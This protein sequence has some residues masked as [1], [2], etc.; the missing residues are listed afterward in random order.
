MNKRSLLPVLSTALLAPAFL[1]GQVY[2]EEA[3]TP[4]ESSAVVATPATSEA[5]APVSN[6][7]ASAT[8]TNEVETPATVAS[9]EAP[10]A[11]AESTKSEE[12]DTV[13]LHT[14]DVHGRIVEEKGVIGDAKLA[15]VIE[16][17]RAKSNQ[18]TLVVDAGDAFQGLPISNSTKGEARAEIL[19]QMQYDAMA[20]GNHEF[21]F[22]L[23]E[24]KKYKE[25]LKFP[26]LSSNTYVNGARLF[27]AS[28]IVDKD[29]TVEGDEFVVIGVTTP[30]TATKTHPKNI[31]GVTFTDPISEVNKVIEE[32][33]AKARAEGKDYK[34][35][36]VLAHL[37]VD[38]TTPVEWRGSTLAEALS[39]NPRLKGKRVTVIDGHSHTVASTTYGNNV[40]Y[41]QTGSYLHNVGKV[42]Y[43]SRQLLGNPTLIAAADAKKLT[44]NPKVEKLVK[45]IKQ[46]YDAE[47]AVE[48]VSNSPVELNGDRENVRVRETNLGNVVADSLYQYGQTGFSHPTDI[49]VTNG[50]GL[51]ET[52]AKGK[53][54]T[55]GN[56]IAVLPFG[57]T[58]SQ[59]Q[60]TGQ[61]VL[62]MF[63]KSLGS[64]LQVD[65]D[66]KKVLDENGQPLLEPSGGFLQVSG[67]KVYYDTN[68]PSGKRVLA[69][70]AKNRTTG[71]YDLLDLAKTYYLATNDFLAAGGDGYTM[72][73]GAREEG[74]SMDAAFEEYLKTA[75]LTQYEKINP[76]SRTIS[77]DSKN[78]SLP[79]ETPQTNTAASDATTNVPLTYEVAGQFSKKAVVSEKALPNTGSEQS[80]FLLLMG[81]VAGLAG[82]LSSRKPKQK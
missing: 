33:Q 55:K 37:G 14:N 20:V 12:K 5:P 72:L 49:A 24:V 52:I 32:V 41:N 78:F 59:I 19:N 28:T 65:K 53:P 51:R 76:N 7:V 18:N 68:L 17:E 23:D 30:E 13:I 71:R 80:I 70:Q 61:Q 79:V 44:A 29:K 15:T 45:D 8:P 60:V 81:M 62:D 21:D 38:T 39:K 47:N 40:T 22:G 48:I 9:A 82:I 3:T 35:Y 1:A 10:S 58:I 74:P 46:K 64:I 6:P 42:I 4:A 57:N 63:E 25:I 75:D 73:G 54:I 77:V 2:A 66:G 27:E 36:V 26:L 67:V 43:K 50:G 31:K 69:I 11:P 56:V 34:H 16:Q